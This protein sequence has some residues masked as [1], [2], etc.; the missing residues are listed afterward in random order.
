MTRRTLDALD[1]GLAAVFG[2]DGLIP[3]AEAARRLSVTAP[4]V[5]ARLKK[6]MADG[7]VRVV[8]LVDPM[9]AASLTVALV[10]V[11]LASHSQL[12]EKLK[13][14]SELD[15]VHWAAVV[16]GRYDIL[17]E[18]VCTG[19]TGDLYDFLDRD[20][21]QVGGVLSSESFVVMKSRRKWLN[22]PPSV[23]RTFLEDSN[24]TRPTAARKEETP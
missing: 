23:R 10:G 15:K 21:S 12:D 6:L 2:E 13:Q 11:K 20:L 7:V 5:R 1:R 8:A 24:R 4:T 16:T 19:A 22:L 14:I 17:V 9:R 18:I 3:V